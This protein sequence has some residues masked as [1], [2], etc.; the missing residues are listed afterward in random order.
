[1]KK[2]PSRTQA[3]P[4]FVGREL[5]RYTLTELIAHGGMG[6][7]YRAHQPGVERAVAIKVIAPDLAARPGFRARFEEEARACAALQHPH[8]LPIYDMAYAGDLPYIVMPY[9]EGGSLAARIAAAPEGLPFSLVSRV[10][11]QVGAALDYL[12]SEGIVHRDLKPGNILLDARGNA[13]LADFGI[14]GRLA[15][16]GSSTQPP[17]TGVYRA[18]ELLAGAAASAASDVY[19]LGIILVEMLCGQRPPEGADAEEIRGLLEERRDLPAGTRFVLDGALN[20]DPEARIPAAQAL[21]SALA[22]ALAGAVGSSTNG[23]PGGDAAGTGSGE[24]SIE[25]EELLTPPPLDLDAAERDAQ[26]PTPPF[27][28]PAYLL[29]ETPQRQAE[30]PPAAADLDEQVATP[31]PQAIQMSTQRTRP[32]AAVMVNRRSERIQGDELRMLNRP[33]RTPEAPERAARILVNAVWVALA[34]SL[35]MLFVLVTLTL[36]RPPLF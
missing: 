32:S 12:H 28:A 17:G 3:A 8:I 14:A 34:L 36:G 26:P 16:P 2:Y 24:S 1:M 30:A 27:P 21:V 10:A 23:H 20:P 4:E 13:Y 11:G 15:E 18:P 5:G 35:V 19:A 6:D 25:D 22:H 7:I 9:M 29:L 33:R 31:S